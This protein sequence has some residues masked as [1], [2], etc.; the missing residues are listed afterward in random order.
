MI[1]DGKRGNCKVRENRGGIL[2][3]LVYGR[4]CSIAIDPMEKKPLY[5]FKPGSQVYSFG[6]AGCNLHCTY[7]QNWMTSQA[8]PEEIDSMDFPPDKIV[9]E[10]ERNGCHAI[11][12]T[13]NEPI[14]FYEYVLDCSMEAKKRGI[15][16][17]VVCNGFVNQEPLRKWC[18]YIDAANIDLKGFSD[19]FYKEYTSAWLE[20]VLETI[21]TLKKKGVWLEI[22]NLIIPG[23]ND[24][25]KTIRK[26]CEW[27]KENVGIDV[28]LHFTAFMPCYKL[29]D[30]LPTSKS[31]LIKAK[32]IADETG[33]RHVYIG[34]VSAEKENNT[35][36]PE[37]GKLLIK[38]AW[39]KIIENNIKKGKCECGHKV[40]G[41]W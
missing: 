12:Y 41:V 15:K 23:A 5:H 28:P 8:M 3:N 19:K 25:L 20:P 39:F 38:R 36:C 17:V 35:Y 16:N 31:I 21:K 18:K 7:C 27:I 9:D 10:A 2:Y 34:N 30:R 29:T 33:L 26:M 22:T 13:Y 4:P 37:C 32:R 6:T 1:L 24:D 14:I 40:E 11:A